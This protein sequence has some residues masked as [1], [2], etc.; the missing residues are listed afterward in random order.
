MRQRLQHH[1]GHLL[2]GDAAEIN[3]QRQAGLYLETELALQL[4]LAQPLAAAVLVGVAGR[5][6]RIG[7]RIPDA[8]ID[9]VEDAGELWPALLQ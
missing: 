4:R 5:Q 1:I 3:H 8:V 9:A 2:V 7:S 6:M